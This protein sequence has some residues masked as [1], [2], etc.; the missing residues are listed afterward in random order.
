MV[1]PL[2]LAIGLSHTLMSGSMSQ[3]RSCISIARV[4]LTIVGICVLIA[5]GAQSA[6]AVDNMGHDAATAQT[7]ADCPPT[8]HGVADAGYGGNGH[9]TAGDDS[10]GQHH[11]GGG[12][13]GGDCCTAGC[14]VGA[15]VVDEAIARPV[16]VGPAAIEG[17]EAALQQ[18]GPPNGKPPKALA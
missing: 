1:N 17:P 15:L 8:A 2:S 4:L 10:Q 5:G 18:L 6:G 13:A 14:S 7:T 12:H 3:P 16:P 11:G 9:P